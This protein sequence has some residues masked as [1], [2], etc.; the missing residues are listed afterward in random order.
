MEI[1]LQTS[2]LQNVVEAS[3]PNQGSKESKAE[4]LEDATRNFE[5]ILLRQFIGE[6]LKPLLHDTL[7]SQVAGA[8]VYQQMISEVIAD[9]LAQSG[10][11]GFSSML[12]IQLAGSFTEMPGEDA[13]K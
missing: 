5:A 2:A 1:S 11:F 3:I 8:G 12:Q 7:G 9:N 10:D 13:L 4:G 6:A